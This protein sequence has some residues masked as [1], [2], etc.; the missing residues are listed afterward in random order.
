MGTERLADRIRGPDGSYGL[1]KRMA[2]R[3]SPSLP[4]T[5]LAV[6]ASRDAGLVGA[7]ALD[8]AA[9]TPGGLAL[10]ELECSL[11][12]ASLDRLEE[13]ERT[14]DLTWVAERFR[15]IEG[16]LEVGLLRTCCRCDIVLVGRSAEVVARWTSALPGDPRVWRTRIGR[17]AARHLFRVTGGLESLAPGEKEVR[18]QVVSAGQSVCSRHRRR[19]LRDLFRDAVA[20]A[21]KAAPY[22][23]PARSIAAL[24]ATRV[25]ELC[26]QP[27]PRVVVV[28]AGAV[29]RQVT[30]LL[31]AS[32]RVSVVYRQNP[33]DERLL[34]SSGAR[35]VRA[36]RLGAEVA[37]ADAVVTAA[38]SGDRC[39]GPADL[40][41]GRP[42]VLVDLGVPRNI[43]PAVRALPKVHLVDL[44][45]LRSLSPREPEAEIERRLEADADRAFAR[46]ASYALESW[47]AETRREAERVRQSELAV[48][49]SFLGSLTD[50]QEV[51]IDRLTRRLVDRLLRAPMERMRALPPGEEGDRLRRLA[52]EL[53]RPD[54]AD[55]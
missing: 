17:E 55:P 45:D 25:L 11:A 48:A 27:F 42:L 46:W 34:R 50:R 37:L 21:E 38:K 3:P 13:V 6:P 28:G 8:P 31:G 19:L 2:G 4:S 26:G 41:R 22:V 7:R 5:P 51:A 32:A 10:A 1:P 24:A 47:V 35:A 29:G 23:P 30:E 44:Q 18:G 36:D 33:P 39:L 12:T 15:A 43:D 54:P 53:L 14:V 9:L 49:R 40:P 52:V 16:T 20:A